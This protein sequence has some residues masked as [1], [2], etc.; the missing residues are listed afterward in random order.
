[1]GW[2]DTLAAKSA[3]QG[4][5]SADFRA[6]AQRKAKATFLFL[7]LAGVV[8]YLAG[9]PWALLSGVLAAWSAFQSRSALMIASRLEAMEAQRSRG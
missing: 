3:E 9:W 6:G 5:T 7:L 1:M 4:K 2:H 8:G